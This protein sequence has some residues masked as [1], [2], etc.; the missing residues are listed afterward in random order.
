LRAHRLAP[1]PRVQRNRC[2]DAEICNWLDD[3]SR[4]YPASTAARCSPHPPSTPATGLSPPGHGDLAGLLTDNGAV[5]TGR[6]RGGGRVALGITLHARGV[7][8]SHSRPC[9]PQTCG[10]V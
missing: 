3:H 7:V 2:A 8:L 1:C 9:H 6:Y 4:F 10:K 5:F